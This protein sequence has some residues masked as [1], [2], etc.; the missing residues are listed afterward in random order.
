MKP[1]P[2]SWTYAKVCLLAA[3]MIA[4]FVKG[5]EP[6]DS[7]DSPPPFWLAAMPILFCGLALPFFL[8]AFGTTGQCL[9]RSPWPAFP[10]SFFGEPLPFLAP[11]R[12][13]LLRRRGPADVSC[14]HA[15]RS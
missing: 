8:R 10:F 2:N 15:V 12:L 9:K 3:T 5:P 14:P 6:I 4:A 11:R 7:G 13:D 1:P